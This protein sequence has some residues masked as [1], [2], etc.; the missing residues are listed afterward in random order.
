MQFLEWSCESTAD[1]LALDEALLLDAE[2]AHEPREWLRLWES[3]DVAVVVGRSSRVAQEVRETECQ[4]RGIR[5]L[6]RD[7]GGAAVVIGPGCLM[8][9]LVLNY[10]LRPHLRAIDAAHRYVLATVADALAPWL[11]GAAMRGTSDLA[12]LNRKFS[13]NSM[14]CKR[15]CFLY[16]GTLL[17]DFPLA[18]IEHC[19]ATPPRQPAY[20]ASRSHA[21]FVTNVNR[22][23]STL[24]QA[25]RS[26]WPDARPCVDWPRQRAAELAREKY[27]QSTW[28]YRF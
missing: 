9:S 4:E 5:I 1:D 24:R 15:D 21:S 22:D 16:H 8:Y 10:R 19:L 25:L 2:A 13:G 18:L 14:R 12:V 27:S 23:G 20:R 17:Y 7:S 6:R 26:A 28:T 11:T 3:R